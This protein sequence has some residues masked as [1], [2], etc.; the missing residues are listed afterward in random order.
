MDDKL[1][2]LSLE[3]VAQRLD[4]HVSTVRRMLKDGRLKGVKLGRVIRVPVTE[5]ERVLDV[6]QGDKPKE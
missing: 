6:N 5:L 3:D 1:R 4:V 2:A